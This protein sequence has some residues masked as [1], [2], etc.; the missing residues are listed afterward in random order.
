MPQL[1]RHP[2]FRTICR[3]DH[4]PTQGNANGAS[5]K[6]RFDAAESISVVINEGRTLT[7]IFSVFAW[8][9]LWFS[10][11]L[12]LLIQCTAMAIKTASPPGPALSTSFSEPPHPLLALLIQCTT[13]AI[14]TPA[15]PGPVRRYQSLGNV[16]T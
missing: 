1:Q 16:G 5:Q 7:S 12:A 14:K 9:P 2:I 11:L 10:P 15:S 13:E 3:C 8:R 4:T 6:D